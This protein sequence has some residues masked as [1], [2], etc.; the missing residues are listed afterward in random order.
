MTTNPRQSQQRVSPTTILRNG[1][2]R[3]LVPI[4]LILTVYLY[5]FPAFTGCGF[6]LPPE[7]DDLNKLPGKGYAAFLETAKLHLP[8]NM[9]TEE[10]IAPQ[11]RK[12]APFRL[13]AL[14]DPQLE[15]DTSIPTSYLGV[16]PHAKDLY[17]HLTFQTE[18]SSLRQRLRQALHDV[19]D[20]FMEDTF[21]LAESVRKHI[22]LF[23]ND[24]YLA[25]IYRTVRWW[26]KPTHVTVLGDLVGSQWLTDE[27]F[28][29]RA[30]RYWGRVFKGGERVPD[31]VAAYPA[32][33]Y[34]LSGYLG[35]LSNAT[36]EEVWTRRIIN[37]A[38]N[39]DIGYAGDINTERTSRFETAFGKINYELRFELPLSNTTVP[40]NG[41]GLFDAETN[42]LSTYLTPELR[43]LVLNDMNLDTPAL[44]QELQDDTYN[45]IN[46]VI[47]TS[48]A[49]EFKGHFTLILTHVPLHKP[50]G[51]CVDS[52]MFTFHDHDGTL[53]EQNL[54]SVPASKGFLEGILGMSGDMNGAGQGKGRRG[55]IMDGHDHA[56]CDV[57]HFINQ[58]YVPEPAAEGEEEKQKEWEVRRWR[59]AK[60][61][62]IPGRDKYPGVREITVRSMMGDFGGNAGL[63]SIW[64]DEQDWEWKA[65]YETCPLGT[66]HMWWVVHS[67][68]FSCIVLGLAWLVMVVLGAVGVDVDGAV[69][70]G[71]QRLF[72]RR[73]R[74][75]RPTEGQ[76]QVSDKLKE[77]TAAIEAPS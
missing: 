61:E 58:S 73:R 54:L 69:V 19:V 72:C 52:P 4:S 68:D 50:E 30:N 8:P 57:W 55:I 21:N 49:V 59:Q 64:F 35:E 45:F 62:K 12:L 24:L 77:K 38:G 29:R 25:H 2:L 65:E 9:T 31:E 71:V 76:V 1:L 37:V 33:E 70:G 41:E 14:G 46:T 47:S 44:S 32:E 26:S 43:V 48:N 17:K 36:K 16:F 56:G 63:L 5:L 3:A 51:V 23:G 74:S 42:Q 15:G 11:T 22:D 20:I 6:P 53:K 60:K 39:H 13:L 66:Q 40:P 7:D 28:N 10:G 27:E 75:D 18:H 67:L 34:D